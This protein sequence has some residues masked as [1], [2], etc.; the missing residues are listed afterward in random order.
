MFGRP[1][2][3]D[4]YSGLCYRAMGFPENFFTVLFALPRVAGYL[5]H[6]RE[7]LDDPDTRICRP[8][9]W[10]TGE[11]LRAYAPA[12]DRAPSTTAD[13]LGPV[14]PS[15]ATRRRLAGSEE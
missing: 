5:A 15:N 12:C 11:W 9:Q 4:F 6:W 8:Q 10:Y 13:S 3:V 1:R 7:Q 14:P 2:Q